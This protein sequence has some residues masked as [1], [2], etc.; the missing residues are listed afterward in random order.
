M[1]LYAK[2]S[3]D[4]IGDEKLM[5]AYRR[6]GA[7]HLYVLPWL[8]AYAK[9]VEDGGRLTVDGSPAEVEDIAQGMPIPAKQ[10]AAGMGELEAIGVLERDEDG[11]LRFRAWKKRSGEQEPAKSRKPSQSPEAIKERVQR[12]R[13]KRK[14]EREQGEP[15]SVTPDV[16]P[17]V[18]DNE[19]PALPAGNAD[20]NATGNA[21][22][23]ARA[24]AQARAGSKEQEKERETVALP[25]SHAPPAA[26]GREEP[27]APQPADFEPAT[28]GLGERPG[29]SPLFGPKSEVP[30][31]THRVIARFVDRYWPRSAASKER[32]EDV[33]RQVL[34][35]LRTGAVLRKGTVAFAYSP[36]R[37]VAKIRAV[38][39]AKTPIRKPDCAIV[40]LL[41]KLAD[42]RDMAD[43]HEERAL[44]QAF[45]EE[46]RRAHSDIAAAEAW[47]SEHPTIAESVATS[48]EIETRGL[49]EGPL[50]GACREYMRTSLVMS[51]WRGR[52]NRPKTA[53]TPVET[54]VEA[55][56]GGAFARA[57][58]PP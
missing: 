13:A 37:L 5:R 35:T 29:E 16:T 25:G 31:E 45:Q 4:I 3:T 2:L 21:L 18:T 34:A 14:R 50:A 39:E 54:P 17:G 23:H 22:S 47:V 11:A 51:A 46:E 28:A 26:E 1:S 49:E 24:Y 55:A 20:G 19:T 12:F 44:R 42:T 36:E 43:T 7:R 15:P 56:V 38:M 57:A 52:G 32:R 41:M 33:H 8:L 30:V 58:R 6:Y 53:K 48:L 27:A 10:I 40:V 9:K